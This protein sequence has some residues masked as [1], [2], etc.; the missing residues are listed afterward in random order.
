MDKRLR[1][2]LTGSNGFLGGHLKKIFQENTFQ[3]S[4]FTRSDVDNLIKESYFQ[5]CSIRKHYPKIPS[6]NQEYDFLIH[7]AAVPHKQCDDFEIS[8]R[9][10]NVKLTKYL[11][12]Y[13]AVNNIFLIYFSSVQVYGSKLKNNIYEG[14]PLNPETNYSK[15]KLESE[16]FIGDMK[17]NKN[18]KGVILRIGNII[19]PPIFN[20]LT[21]LKLFA[22]G[23]IYESIKDK[24]IT[25]KNNP[26]IRRSFVSID[27][28]IKTIELIIKKISENSKDIP[29]IINITD[30]QSYSLLEFAELVACRQ[31]LI[32]NQIIN[33][34]FIDSLKK[35]V[36]NYS[37]KNTYL[38]SHLLNY[39]SYSIQ[40]KI[41]QMLEK[42]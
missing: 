37:I 3:I 5:D 21:S 9:I 7:T 1:I 33:I 29:E 42:I 39:N 25:I 23:A 14:S 2:L 30:G 15:M 32:N 31:K 11:T 10:I 17:K 41:D 16:L 12:N 35:E 13:C 24:K 20:N 19:G 6:L 38:K 18:L 4:A 34:N 8:S 36:S 40:N 28:L 22:N 26:L 27:I